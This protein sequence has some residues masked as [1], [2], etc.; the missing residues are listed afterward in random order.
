MSISGID[1]S[2]TSSL[3][4]D[5]ISRLRGKQGD[6]ADEAFSSS[7]AN[8]LDGDGVISEEEMQAARESHN[9]QM[10]MMGGLGMLMRGMDPG[11][12]ADTLVA[13]KD[14]DGDGMLSQDE[15]GLKDDFFSALD[16]DEDGLLSSGELASAMQSHRP[17]GPPKAE[18]L[19]DAFVTKFDA[20]GDGLLS[21]EES[22]LSAERFD[23]LDA[24]G[25]GMVSGEELTEGLKAS[26]PGAQAA[27]LTEADS[28]SL[29]APSG[30]AGGAESGDD[31]DDYDAYDLNK[32][33][34]VSM[35]ELRQALLNGDVSL[36]DVFG[37]DQSGGQSGLMRIA[38]RAYHAQVGGEPAAPQQQA[39]A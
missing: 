11:S 10:S 25:D 34:V 3:Y 15:S 29:A 33:G 12:I 17:M 18:D 27:T 31:D 23:S 28:S 36:A 24:D 14:A 7:I 30:Q 4:G 1:S 22:G 26:A 19:A 38:M 2:T 21:Q 16:G 39:V 6:G 37:E 8:D 5:L 35:E 9:G 20:D 13:D 32:D